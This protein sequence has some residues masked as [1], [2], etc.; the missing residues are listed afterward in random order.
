[1]IYD[2][3][4]FLQPIEEDPIQCPLLIRVKKI[5]GL[6]PKYN[7]LHR[8]YERNTAMAKAGL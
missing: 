1:M 5:Y 6:S 3:V 8:F 4:S 7:I 2:T